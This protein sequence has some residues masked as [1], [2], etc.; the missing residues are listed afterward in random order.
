[1]DL[2]GIKMHLGKKPECYYNDEIELELCPFE[3]ESLVRLTEERALAASTYLE[4]GLWRVL[5]D[6]LQSRF[7]EWRRLRDEQN[8]KD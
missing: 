5:K 3:L 6:K 2:G 7:D 4:Q 8:E 1:M